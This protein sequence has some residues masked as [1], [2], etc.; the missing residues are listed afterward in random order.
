MDAEII[1]SCVESGKIN[2]NN[3]CIGIRE[4]EIILT[5]L[6]L[7]PDVHIENV[8]GVMSLIEFGAWLRSIEANE[9]P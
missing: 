8:G 2:I 5:V 6:S 3:S 7:R 9:K 1:K 4:L